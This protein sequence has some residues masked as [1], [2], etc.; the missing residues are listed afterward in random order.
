ML[1]PSWG[2][3]AVCTAIGTAGLI[4]ADKKAWGA[5]LAFIPVLCIIAATIVRLRDPFG[6]TPE[7]RQ[8]AE[9][10]GYLAALFWSVVIGLSLPVVG[11]YLGRSRNQ[12]PGRTE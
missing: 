5:T 8:N 10:W 7:T 3:I 6:L 12:K 9:T 1:L 4:A 2:L 11:I